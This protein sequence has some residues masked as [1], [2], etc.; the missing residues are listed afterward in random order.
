M[1]KAVNEILDLILK[2]YGHGIIDNFARSVVSQENREI[3][4][5]IVY[6]VSFKISFKW[7]DRAQA[8]IAC[9]VYTIIHSFVLSLEMFTFHVVLNSSPSSIFSFLFYNNF[10]EIKI[11]VFK[12]C[13]LSGMF[14]YAS[15][16]GVERI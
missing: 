6:G 13:D 1:I 11:T 4:I 9:L 12:K 8:V 10:T 2:S 16:D 14:N 7:I 5:Q 3:Q 15:N